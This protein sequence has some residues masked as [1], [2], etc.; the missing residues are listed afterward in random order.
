MTG[1]YF[2]DR[3]IVLVAP[4]IELPAKL[5]PALAG[6]LDVLGVAILD[7]ILVLVVRRDFEGDYVGE[8]ESLLRR[9]SRMEIGVD[10]L[11]LSCK[12]SNIHFETDGQ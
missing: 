4:P 11:E 10:V 1:R 6:D 8:L 5:R 12:V 7:D 2:V 3:P 9:W